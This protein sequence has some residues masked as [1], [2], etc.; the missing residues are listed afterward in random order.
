VVLL[1]RLACEAVLFRLV[2]AMVLFVASRVW[3]CTQ[4]G[5]GVSTKPELPDARV[6]IPMLRAAAWFPVLACFLA[7]RVVAVWDSRQARS[8]VRASSAAELFE[9]CKWGGILS[10]V[11]QAQALRKPPIVFA[12]RPSCRLLP[13][14]AGAVPSIVASKP[15]RHYELE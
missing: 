9:S 4:V 11:P 7:G 13:T 3:I 15:R 8:A 6:E 5:G 2:A 1:A 10:Q 14:V 12:Q